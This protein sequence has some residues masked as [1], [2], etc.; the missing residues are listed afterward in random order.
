MTSEP[1]ESKSRSSLWLA[2]ELLAEFVAFAD[3]RATRLPRL[4]SA[5]RKRR[6]KLVHTLK[7]ADAR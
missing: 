2:A 3:G 4:F 7:A 1:R 6:K 5:I